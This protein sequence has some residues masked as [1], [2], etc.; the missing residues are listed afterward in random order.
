[1]AVGYVQATIADGG[2]RATVAWVVG[3]AWQ[4]RGY[5]RQGAREMAGW[6]AWH[7]VATIEA[8][9][10]PA[11]A[12]SGAVVASIGLRPTGRMAGGEQLWTGRAGPRPT[13]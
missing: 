5:A 1:M 13:G 8:W 3:L 10:A 6:L 12:A 2:T 11:N 7:G 4:G 9:I